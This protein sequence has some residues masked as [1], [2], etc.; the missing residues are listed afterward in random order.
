M[1]WRHTDAR[2]RNTPSVKSSLMSLP[3]MCVGPKWNK[4]AW[5]R[6]TRSS[7]L[8]PCR[9]GGG[10]VLYQIADCT[11]SRSS[12][13]RTKTDV[14]VLAD[15]PVFS[16]NRVP[17]DQRRSL[18]SSMEQLIQKCASFR[19]PTHC[20]GCILWI[21]RLDPGSSWIRR[22]LRTSG[23]HGFGTDGEGL[24]RPKIQ[25]LSVE[26][27]IRRLE[28]W[29]RA[30]ALT[31]MR[32]DS[33]ECRPHTNRSPDRVSDGDHTSNLSKHPHTL[34]SQWSLDGLPKDNSVINRLSRLS[35]NRRSH[36]GPLSD[37]NFFLL[38]QLGFVLL[39]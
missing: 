18:N 1:C 38:H 34:R 10:A 35:T 7:F 23:G 21:P 32:C 20:C 14:A 16:R 4:N 31:R 26:I 28:P 13:T 27:S 15:Q 33:D 25:K 24:Y 12:S 9:L 39:S 22:V 2:Y 17:V 3:S 29:P 8:L 11:K 19:P 30:I 37:C 5:R 36:G 6:S